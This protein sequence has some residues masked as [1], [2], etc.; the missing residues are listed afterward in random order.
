MYDLPITPTVLFRV[1]NQPAG[2]ASGPYGSA[3][4]G[5]AVTAFTLPKWF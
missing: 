1:Q 3:D 5:A 2:S 4:G